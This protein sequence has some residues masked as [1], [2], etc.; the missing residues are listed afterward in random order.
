M[1]EKRWDGDERGRGVASA[2]VF[3]PGVTALQEQL[4]EDDW[5]AED[6]HAHLVP[7][8]ARACAVVPDVSLLETR[9]SDDGVLDVVLE[10]RP[11]ADSPS[12]TYR[13]FGI[14]GSFAE[15]STHVTQRRVD[16]TLE[17]DVVTGLLPDQTHFRTHGHLV[18]LRVVEQ[19][20]PH[21]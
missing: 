21:G 9:V 4:Y 6:P 17:Y 7:H 16:S 1:S 13:V 3:A 10:W 12:L 2:A 19:P 14:I 15:P 20:S 8:I 18:R 5:V 11:T